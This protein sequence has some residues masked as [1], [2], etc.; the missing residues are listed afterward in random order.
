MNKRRKIQ[1]LNKAISMAERIHKGEN[2]VMGTTG[3]DQLY[4][5]CRLF[6]GIEWNSTIHLD[7]LSTTF[8]LESY[9]PKRAQAKGNTYYYSQDK[10]GWG[11]RVKLLKRILQDV[12]N[13]EN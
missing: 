9:K 4:G 11:Y 13:D 7:S 12:Q 1:V 5:I 6:N 10:Q 3:P 8:H 2:G